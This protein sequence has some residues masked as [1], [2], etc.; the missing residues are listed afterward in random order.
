MKSKP[1]ATLNK[2]QLRAEARRRGVYSREHLHTSPSAATADALR[3]AI[4]RKQRRKRGAQIA[5]AV[6]SATIASAATAATIELMSQSKQSKLQ[7][8]PSPPP[9]VP[10]IPPMLLRRVSAILQAA[11]RR[12]RG[13]LTDPERAL[14]TKFRD[15]IG[16]YGLANLRDDDPLKVTYTQVLVALAHSATNSQE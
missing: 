7:S 10:D 9:D 1:L 2:E 3:N 4:E 13:V 14:L 16:V 11:Q 5:S 12:R 8:P 6:L 15:R